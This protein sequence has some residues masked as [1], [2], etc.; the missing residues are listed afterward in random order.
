LIR[1]AAAFAAFH[2]TKECPITEAGAQDTSIDPKNKESVANILSVRPSSNKP[3][4][5]M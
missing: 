2:F 1:Q 3:G 5:E 4:G